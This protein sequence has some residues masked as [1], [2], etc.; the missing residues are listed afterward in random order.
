MLWS[1]SPFSSAQAAKQ[2]N[3]A[4]AQTKHKSRGTVQQNLMN[5]TWKI[6]IFGILNNQLLN[7]QIKDVS[8]AFTNWAFAQKCE[9]NR[10]LTMSAAVWRCCNISCTQWRC[11]SF[12][13][14]QTWQRWYHHC[15]ISHI[16]TDTEILSPAL[17]GQYICMHITTHV[18]AVSKAIPPPSQQTHQPVKT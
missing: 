16:A 13:K 3:S 5:I 14:D 4:K 10:Y 2:P 9:I 15:Y 1:V 12:H 8:N 11:L 18:S 17:S 6:T 7:I